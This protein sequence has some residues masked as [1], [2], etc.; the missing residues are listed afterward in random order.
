MSTNQSEEYELDDVVEMSLEEYRRNV[1]TGWLEIAEPKKQII[2]DIFLENPQ[3]RFTVEVINQYLDN[4]N[5]QEVKTTIEYLE[6]KKLIESLDD[7]YL[8]NE[9]SDI[10]SKIQELDRLIKDS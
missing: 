6:K 9:D 4:Y 3:K 8:I 7:T 5:R 1:S 2:L 10:V